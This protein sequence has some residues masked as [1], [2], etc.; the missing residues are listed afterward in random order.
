MPVSA[1]VQSKGKLPRFEAM[2]QNTP[3][4][5]N[6]NNKIIKLLVPDTPLPEVL[7]SQRM[8]NFTAAVAANYLIS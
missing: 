8:Q 3:R 4:F 5:R 7:S 6:V 2:L 1:A